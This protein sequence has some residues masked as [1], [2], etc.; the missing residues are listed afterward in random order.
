MYQAL[1]IRFPLDVQKIPQTKTIY[2]IY[3]QV[4]QGGLLF[5]VASIGLFDANK[6]RVH[7]KIDNT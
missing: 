7:L 3:T 1:P 2:S 4:P 5:P 6:K